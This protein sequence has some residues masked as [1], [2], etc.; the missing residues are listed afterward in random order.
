[1]IAR[2]LQFLPTPKHHCS[3]IDFLQVRRDIASKLAKT[4]TRLQ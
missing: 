4:T 1:L 2:H 3:E